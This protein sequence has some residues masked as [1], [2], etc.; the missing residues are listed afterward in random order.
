[1]QISWTSNLSSLSTGGPNFNMKI[2]LE[3]GECLQSNKHRINSL[4]IK[5]N[6]SGILAR[7]V[8]CKWAISVKFWMNYH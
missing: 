3:T 2:I 4:Y 7:A 6:F 8:L 1:M 5:S